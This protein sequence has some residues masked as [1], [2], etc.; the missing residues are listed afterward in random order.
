MTDAGTEESERRLQ[1]SE[2]H[3][4]YREYDFQPRIEAIRPKAEPL[5][6]DAAMET[7][8]TTKLDYIEHP[9][10]RQTAAR[11]SGNNLQQEG[12][13]DFTSSY[14]QHFPDVTGSRV[15]PIRQDKNRQ[16]PGKFVGEPSY[17][18]E[19][20]EWSLPPRHQREVSQWAPPQDPFQ[21]TSTA[22]KDFTEHTISRREMF[23]RQDEWGGP[24]GNFQ[25]STGYK[26]TFK[27]HE[28]PPRRPRNRQLWT[29]P[30]VK[31]SG[32]STNTSDFTGAYQPKRESL[33]P[34][35]AAF[36]SNAP[37][38]SSTTSKDSYKEKPLGQKYVHGYQPYVRPEGHMDLSTTNQSQ[39][40]EF[41]LTRQVIEKPSS[42]HILRGAGPMASESGYN[43]EFVEHRAARREMLKPQNNYEPP[44]SKFDGES[45]AKGDYVE[46][47]LSPRETYRPQWAPVGSGAPFESSTENKASFVEQPVQPRLRREKQAYIAPSVPFQ[48]STTAAESYQG[49]VA[50]RTRNF[51]PE[52]NTISSDGKFE[53]KT[54]FMSDFQEHEVSPR[55]RHEQDRYVRPEGEMDMMTSNRQAFQEMGRPQRLPVLKPGS[56]H[57]MKR[58]GKF[59]GS[60]SYAGDFM[61][62][63]A[64]VR[65][66]IKPRDEY[67][68]S[69]DRFEGTTTQKSDF[70]GAYAPRQTNFRPQNRPLQNLNAFEDNVRPD[71]R[72]WRDASPQ[73]LTV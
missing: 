33:G 50:P 59:D 24:Q 10:A 60:S 19:F 7:A 46:K 15:K 11:P 49:L 37:F 8:T 25:S 9:V 61:A 18:A 57:L 73:A 35:R 6:H 40:R 68:P 41:P 53:G 42:S 20:Q 3:S 66:L 23:K 45:T 48:A 62:P 14:N 32:V 52:N 51:K 72:A 70:R 39:F 67:Q 63:M 31:F 13:H 69:G 58:E 47:L 21:G 4:R 22:K 2:Y 44:S 29:S 43:S 17:K 1:S 12:T 34:N 56:S 38:D 64:P 71:Y 54:T 16:E 55:F 65:Q 28:L 26:D 5:P 30:A 36:N 27:E